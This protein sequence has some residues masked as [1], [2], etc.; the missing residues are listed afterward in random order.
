MERTRYNYG[1]YDLSANRPD[2]YA[3]VVFLPRELDMII[4][5][6]REK[7]DPDY[8]L[9]ASHITI[10]FPFETSRS[11]DMVSAIVSDEVARVGPLQLELSSIGDFYPSDPI[12]Y[13]EVKENVALNQLHKSLY[14]RLDL[15]L[16][17]RH[18]IPHV[19]IAKEI[20]RHR[21][22]LVKERIVPYLSDENFRPRT[23]DLVSPVTDHKWV[24]VR[25]FPLVR[26]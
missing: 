26:P 2:L 14:G 11:L 18:Y 15:P 17:H 3:V 1:S 21:V 5:L 8:N 12:I 6:L 19:T 22:I 23:L 25:S 20:S 13:W 24:S 10:V 4:S 16:P 7:F 9:I